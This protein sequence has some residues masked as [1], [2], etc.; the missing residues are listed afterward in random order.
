MAEKTTIVGVAL[1]RNED[2]FLERAILN[3]L[4]FCD[5]IIIADNCSKDGTWK[6]AQRLAAEHEKIEARRI[7]HPG[8][9]HEM[10]RGYAGKRAWVLGVD[11][12]EIYDPAG[13]VKLREEMLE[14]RYDRWWKIYGNVLNAVDINYESM[15]ASGYMAPPCRSM[16]KLYNFG[17]I[18][19]WN[20][21]VA[22]RLHGGEIKFREG[23]SES[24]RFSMYEEHDW[25]TSPFRLLHTCFL[26]RSSLDADEGRPREN[27]M[28]KT[29]RGRLGAVKRL[30]GM[31][32]P[33]GD[34][35]YKNRKYMRGDLVTVDV[36]AFF[37]S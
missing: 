1:V 13:L 16:T 14:G 22:E 30:L 25:E 10:I 8:A 36:S 4:D 26:K 17:A 35:M 21:P 2:V 23:W 3:T 29:A 12:D 19:S 11:G 5:R 37:G 18:E 28:E 33:G 24:S 9:S 7:R 27:I 31:T 15:R 20:G 34:E 6:I 32:P